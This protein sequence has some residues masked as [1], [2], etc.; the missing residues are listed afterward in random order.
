MV[1]VPHHSDQP[2]NAFRAQRLGMGR[3]IPRGQYT[4]DRGIKELRC[5]LEDP[6]CLARAKSIAQEIRQEDGI[7]RAC[8]ELEK[9]AQR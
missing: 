6:G 2:D 3:V 7:A 8:D 9:H 5:L 4:V 1:I